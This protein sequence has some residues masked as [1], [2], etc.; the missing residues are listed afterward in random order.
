MTGIGFGERR[1]L[2][3]DSKTGQPLS[4]GSTLTDQL[5][6]P[7]RNPLVPPNLMLFKE[8]H[9]ED[10]RNILPNSCS[11]ERGVHHVGQWGVEIGGCSGWYEAVAKHAVI[12]RAAEGEKETPRALL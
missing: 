8:E 3:L 12:A 7:D 10:I 2:S 5:W 6:S 11:S 9:Q 1:D 4:L